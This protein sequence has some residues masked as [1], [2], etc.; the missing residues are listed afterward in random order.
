MKK[1][2]VVTGGAGFIGSHLVDRL[3]SDGNE[4]VVIDNLSTGKRE[5]INPDANFICFDLGADNWTALINSQIRN[6]DAV[7]HMAGLN[8]L[9]R[10]CNQPHIF[11][12]SNIN[13][14]LNLLVAANDSNIKKII[15]SS[16]LGLRNNATDPYSVQKLSSENYCKS[17]SHTYGIQCTILR[18]ADVFG[19]RMSDFSL[20]YGYLSKCLKSQD[21]NS[22]IGVAMNP[23]QKRDFIHVDDVVSANL[24]SESTSSESC[25][26]FNVG[27]GKGISLKEVSS[28]TNANIKFKRSSDLHCGNVLKADAELRNLG[29][30]PRTKLCSWLKK[31]EKS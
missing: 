12:K 27:H 15:Y 4:V 31:S 14:T 18:Y 1:K 30:L 24:L 7:F 26:L 21:L 2:F 9:T 10:S 20:P 3:L 22:S 17:F 19:D 25:R 28:Q 6:A 16:C 5:N 11:H 13:A 8:G 23:S 29:W